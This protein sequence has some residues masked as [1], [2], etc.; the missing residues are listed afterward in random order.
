MDY[1]KQKQR[2]EKHAQRVKERERIK[3]IWHKNDPKKKIPFHKIVVGYLFLILNVVLIYAFVAMWHF[4]DLTHL[5]LI[6]TDIAAQVV[7]F[8]IYSRHSTA[9][10][11]AGGIVFESA[12]QEI[13]SRFHSRD[14]LTQKEKDEAVG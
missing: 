9:E 14:E 3:K 11:T 13:K 5:G 4:A 6:I 1:E 10:N 12:M 8:L 2:A 7:T